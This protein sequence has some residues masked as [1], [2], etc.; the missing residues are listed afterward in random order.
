MATYGLYTLAMYL[1]NCYGKKLK[2]ENEVQVVR[3]FFHVFGEFDW[4]NFMITV[5]GPIKLSTFYEKLRD[6]FGHDLVKLAMTERLD[7]FQYDSP[8]ESIQQLMFTPDDLEPLM[9]KYAAIKLLYHCQ[10]SNPKDLGL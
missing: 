2:F 9:D 3:H 10:I 7:Y 4:D 6:E 8:E 1:F 5:Y